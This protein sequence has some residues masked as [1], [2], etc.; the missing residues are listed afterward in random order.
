MSAGGHRANADLRAFVAA[1]AMLWAA[2][3]SASEEATASERAPRWS[4]R[5]EGSYYSLPDDTDYVL[6]RALADRGLLHLEARYNAEALHTLSAF[7]GVN[8]AFGE[9][10]RLELTPLLG[11]MVGRTNGLA[12]ALELGLSLW[13][14]ELYSEMEYVFDLGAPEANFFSSWT[15]LSL[16]PVEW[17]RAGLI[18]ERTRTVTTSFDLSRGFLLGLAY[19]HVSAAVHVLNPGAEDV[20]TIFLLAAEW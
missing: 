7:L 5:G 9:R 8:F 16:W 6:W 2:P 20:Y 3:A 11:G 14:L 19:R 10:L 12:P 18:F 4:F 15:E 13:K 17:A 1:L